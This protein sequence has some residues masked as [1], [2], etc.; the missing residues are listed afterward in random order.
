MH[1]QLYMVLITASGGKVRKVDAGGN[2]AQS[3]ACWIA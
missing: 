2:V 3:D 1:I